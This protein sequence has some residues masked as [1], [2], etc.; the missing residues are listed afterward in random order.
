MADKNNFPI[1][2]AP[3]APPSCGPCPPPPGGPCP[4]RPPFP[5]PVI[6]GTSQ[7]I[8]ARYVPRFAE[9][10]EWSKDRDY[11]QLEIV[12]TPNGDSYASRCP[13]PVGVDISNTRYWAKTSSQSVQVEQYR[14]EVADLSKQVTDNNQAVDAMGDK[15]DGWQQTMDGWAGQVDQWEETVGQASQEIA[16]LQAN[17]SRQDASLAEHAQSIAEIL[18]K[19]NTQDASIA[20][21]AEAIQAAQDTQVEF[22]AAYEQDKAALQAADAQNAAAIAQSDIAIRQNTN[23]IQDNAVN[24]AAN[25]AEIARHGEILTQHA[26]KFTALEAKDQEQ[27]TKMDGIRAD[28][29]EAEAKIQ[30]NADAISHLQQESTDTLDEIDTLKDA[31]TQYAAEIAAL[32]E[33]DSEHDGR[34]DALKETFYEAEADIVNNADAISRLETNQGVWTVDHPGKSISQ[35]VTANANAA[36]AAKAAADGAATTAAQANTTAQAAKTTADKAA[37]DIQ[38]II[39]TGGGWQESR[40]A[41]LETNQGAWTADHPDKSISQA[42]TD[43]ANAAQAATDAANA[44]DTK[45]TQANTAAQAAQ[46]AAATAD[47]KA[48]AAQA[49]AA[50]ADAKAVAAQAAANVAQTAADQAKTDAAD[51]L[52]QAQTAEQKAESL[53]QQITIVSN[54]GVICWG[55][56]GNPPHRLYSATPVTGFPTSGSKLFSSFDFIGFAPRVTSGGG[57]DGYSPLSGV[58]EAVTVSVEQVGHGTT[59]WVY[60]L[61]P[62]FACGAI[63]FL[64]LTP[65]S[66]EEVAAYESAKAQAIYDNGW[67]NGPAPANATFVYGPFDQEGLAAIQGNYAMTPEMIVVAYPPE[68][69]NNTWYIRS[70]KEIIDNDPGT[71]NTLYV[72]NDTN[73][74]YVELT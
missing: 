15:I 22:E 59:Y 52:A 51:A 1:A 47:T 54:Q 66:P 4:P 20:A 28:L 13:V 64:S 3:F 29:T 70:T 60:S 39:D 11:E 8:G 16:E 48:T 34:L 7:Y 45:A 44:A 67:N 18:A 14:Q 32:K 35:A 33:K 37:A 42:V 23:N 19:N 71:D 41:D 6:P 65:A 68:Y 61:S 72:T 2:P 56:S 27:D 24:I 74:A 25:A 12:T 40:V 73:T 63:Q 38:N 5:R 62:G 31:D 17:D 26:G 69:S 36:Q 9:P 57:Y 55:E 53:E 10:I 30:Q 46:T 43:N 49:A 50:V 21:N 58:L